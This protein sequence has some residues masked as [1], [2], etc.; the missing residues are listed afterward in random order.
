MALTSGEAK[1]PWGA[2]TWADA[3]LHT[4]NTVILTFIGQDH[5][6]SFD[7]DAFT[8]KRCSDGETVEGR[9]ATA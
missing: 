4:P 1:T 5:L 9:L 6:L 3:T 2:G 7:G 8:S